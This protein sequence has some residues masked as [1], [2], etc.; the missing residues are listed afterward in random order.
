MNLFTRSRRFGKSLNMSMLKYFFEIGSD[1]NLF[2]GLKI[3]Q[4]KELCEKYMG[5]FPAISISL[6]SVDGL[7]YET[8]STA[9]RNV[10]GNEAGR[11]YFS[12]DSDKLS[13]DE[14]RSLFTA[15]RSG[16][17]AGRSLYHD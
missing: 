1:S 6:K 7:K 8:A 11:F 9:L 2:H 14:K 12:K 15:D 17:G 16:N 10:I 5:K 4:K 3:A 13:E